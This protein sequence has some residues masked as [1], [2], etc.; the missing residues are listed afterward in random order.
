MAQIKISLNEVSDTA[1]RIRNLNQMMYES[2]V[3]MKN[4]MNALDMNWISDAS[5]EIR[6]K[7]NQFATKFDNQKDVIDSYARFLDLT[8]STYEMLEATM[9]NNA[10]TMQ[11]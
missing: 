2:L 9:T 1:N 6:M 3:Q 4:D 8:V 10:S 5:Q 7:F 11:S